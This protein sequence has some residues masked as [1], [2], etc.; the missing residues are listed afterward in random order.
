MSKTK[1]INQIT[2]SMMD[3]LEPE[4]FK[5]LNENFIQLEN[6]KFA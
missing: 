1:P 4:G 6:M 5:N 3:N 2:L